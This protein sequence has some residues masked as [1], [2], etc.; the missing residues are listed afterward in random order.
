MPFGEARVIVQFRSPL[1]DVPRHREM[2]PSLTER[3]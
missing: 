3:L 1:P 2:T